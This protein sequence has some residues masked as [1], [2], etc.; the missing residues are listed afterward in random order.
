MEL[1]E[2]LTS[3][4]GMLRPFK[5]YLI[6]S[7]VSEDDQVVFYGCPGTC[8]PFIELLSFAVRDLQATFVF[9]PFI[10]ES[11]AKTLQE[12]KDVGM[13]TSSAQESIHPKVVVIMGGLAMPNVPVSAE[14]V[15][16]VLSKY[17]AKVMG[18]C[19]MGMFYTAG[20]EKIINFEM[21]IDAT[22][23]PVKVWK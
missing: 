2:T 4:A 18:V 3:V 6:E 20:W 22:I 16:A 9:V 8:T 21:V 7:G 14:D 15:K 1:Q 10:D 19:F 13:Q 12:V 23:D 5:K 17:D 11:K